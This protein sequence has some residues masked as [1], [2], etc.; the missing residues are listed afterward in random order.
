MNGPTPDRTPRPDHSSTPASSTPVT[1]RGP[2]ATRLLWLFPALVAVAAAVALLGLVATGAARPGALVPI[3]PLVTWG[4]PVVRALHHTGAM[5]AIGAGGVTVLLAPGPSRDRPTSLGAG[6]GTIARFGAGGAALWAASSGALV[7]LSALEAAGAHSGLHLWHLAMSTALGQFQLA[8]AIA[9][10]VAALFY[11]AA[12]STVMVCWGLAASVIGVLLLGFEGHAGASLDHTNAVNAMALHLLAMTIWAGGLLVLGIMGPV[13]GDGLPVAVRRFSPW[14][15]ACVA[16]LAVSGLISGTI[17]LSSPW[18]LL[19]VPYGRIMLAKAVLLCGL[20][21]LGALQRRRLGDA[22]RFRHLALTEGVMLAAVIGLSIALARTGPPV[23]QVIPAEGD[24]RTLSLVGYLPPSQ[25]FGIRAL[26][27]VWQPDWVATLIGLVMAGLYLTGVVRLRRRGDA[28]SLVRTVPFLL[29]CLA[30]IWVMSGGA[31]AWGRY[32]FDAHMVQ[33]MA[34][35]MIVPPL[36]V[37][38]GPVTLLTRAVAPRTDG[39]RSIRE[40]VLAA[41]HS[42]Y[43]RIVSTPPMAGVFFAGSLVLFYFTPLFG[44]S[45]EHHLGHVLMTVHFLLAGYLFAWVLFGVDP[46]TKPINPVLKLVTLL[47]TLSFHA[48][49]GVAVVSATWIIAQDWYTQLGMYSAPQLEHIQQAGGSIMWG[50]S[51]VPTVF[52]SIIVAY[53][54]TRSD[55]R[56]ARQYDRKA[57][58]DGNAELAAY[59]EYLASLQG[60][61]AVQQGS[62]AG[63]PDG[64]AVSDDGPEAQPNARAASDDVPDTR[65]DGAGAADPAVD[66]EGD[67]A[68][69]GHGEP[70][71]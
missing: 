62:D 66:A 67:A 25:P 34:M 19:T 70:R 28:W 64:D 16:G 41:L 12:R 47:V 18:Q 6:R 71:S 58:R 7:P 65:A 42:R 35:M 53:Q 1:T 40:W 23:P 21:L 11:L 24:L 48:F 3:S 39:S 33:H 30:L 8:V 57:E 15:L 13:L 61:G 44:L 20:A 45:M 36:W 68:G 56:R 49:F 69:T 9:A 37:L 52:Y 14:A 59:N 17:R 5:L 38:G 60:G 22:L 54:W 43:A 31:A 46:G 27:T 26:L 32:R 63:R 50:V 29:G 51:E 10:L 4:I 55:E 2:R